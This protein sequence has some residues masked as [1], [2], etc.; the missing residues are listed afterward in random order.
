MRK[1]RKMREAEE[2]RHSVFGRVTRIWSAVFLIITALFAGLLTYANILPSKYLAVAL[3]IILVLF[4]IIFP[5]LFFR[6][7]K[8]GKKG[9]AFVLSLLLTAA[10]ALGS[11]YLAGTLNFIGNIS[12]IGIKTDKYYVVVRDDGRYN[13]LSDIEGE[14]VYYIREGANFEQAMSGLQKDVSVNIVE[15]TDIMASVDGL[16]SGENNALFMSAANYE[17]MK[18]VRET[19]E[20]DTKILETF[21]VKVNIPSFAKPVDVSTEPFNIVI[22]GL[23]FEG[24]FDAY[25]SGRSDVNMVATVNPETHTILL[26]SIPRDYYV[27]L[28]MNGAYDKLTHSGVYG[29]EETVNTIGNLMGI[30]VNYYVRVN[31]STVV[32]LVD[33]IGGI[34]IN[35]EYAFTTSDG[36]YYFDE[37]I[38]H[39]NGAEAL[40]FARERKAFSSGDLQRN[41][42]Q[43][44]VLSAI[45]DKISN[46]ST[47]LLNYTSILGALDGN[48]ATNLS[49]NEMK[50]L[51]KAQADSMSGWK[52]ES[53]NV[54]GVS[55]SEP[56]YSAGNAYASVVLQDSESIAAASTR[57][58]EVMAE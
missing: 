56:C 57:I 46:S 19:F 7:F 36:M 43:Q 53:Q 21:S 5:I 3:G 50:T 35:S 58:Q 26:T 39:V 47:L 12:D 25:T 33:A 44:I 40:R 11:V 14:T 34:D 24:S 2:K 52:V 17:S 18:E 37:G 10:F 1:D 27:P 4:L 28:A 42:N 45:I 15:S 16:L 32:T 48:M 9:V 49:S 41:R 6:K 13:T 38:N 54:I 20:D 8:N 29:V 22:S 23:D 55:S 31:F 30:D 51:V